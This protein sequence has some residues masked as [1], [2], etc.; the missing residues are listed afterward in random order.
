[1]MVELNE[2]GAAKVFWKELFKGLQQLFDLNKSSWKGV[3]PEAAAP[4]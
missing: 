1:M 3:A 2:F 4:V